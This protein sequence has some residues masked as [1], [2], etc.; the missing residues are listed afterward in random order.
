ML[1]IDT[2]KDI[3]ELNTYFCEHEP[4]YL[5]IPIRC[6][7]GKLLVQKC[8]EEN[9]VKEI[10]TGKVIPCVTIN[11]DAYISNSEH[12]LTDLLY[13]YVTKPGDRNPKYF[14]VMTDLT[15]LNYVSFKK[16]AR[17]VHKNSDSQKLEEYINNNLTLADYL[18][19][20][21]MRRRKRQ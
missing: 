13:S 5:N 16:M 10:I 14:A 4:D 19:V 8:D 6:Y 12:G 15:D 20:E 3:Y 21:Q 1:K 7:R 18:E 17:Y 9:Y 11:A 2:D